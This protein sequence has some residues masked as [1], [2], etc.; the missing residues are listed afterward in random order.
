MKTLM[1]LFIAS[2]LSFSIPNDIKLGI[3]LKQIEKEY[4]DY[5]FKFYKN[6]QNTSFSLGM[7]GYWK[8]KE[9]CV[10]HF[11][12]D[13]LTLIK[14]FKNVSQYEEYITNPREVKNIVINKNNLVV[15][16]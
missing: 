7:L 13:T 9:G 3:S 15:S 6:I 1:I 2:T 4:P 8:G 14:T 5:H 10:L 12:D 11:N 16:K